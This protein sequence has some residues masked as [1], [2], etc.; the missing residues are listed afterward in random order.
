M[1]G[2]NQIITLSTSDSIPMPFHT[3]EKLYYLGN[4]ILSQN[5]DSIG[6]IISI[7]LAIIGGTVIICFLIYYI[8][9]FF[10]NKALRTY[11]NKEREVEFSNFQKKSLYELA[12]RILEKYWKIRDSSINNAEKSGNSPLESLCEEKKKLFVNTCNYINAFLTKEK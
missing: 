10:N 12:T 11:Q 5:I 4:E 9:T 8:Y 1:S 3:E 2:F 6:D 7:N